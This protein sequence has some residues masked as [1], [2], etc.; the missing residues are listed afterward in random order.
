MKPGS[1]QVKEL[2]INNDTKETHRFQLS[3]S[4]FAMGRNGAPII[5]KPGTSSEEDMKYALSKWTTLTPSYI[6]LKSGE[7]G[8]V[9]ITVR[10]PNDETGNFAAWTLISVDNIKAKTPLSAGNDPKSMSIG[11][12]PNF[13]FGIYVFQ[14]PPNVAVNNVEIQKV[15]FLDSAGVKNVIMNVRNVGDGIGF[16]TSYLELTSLNTGKKMKLGTKQFT[17]LPQYFRDFSYELPKDLP[18]GK[19]SAIGVIDYGNEDDI[20]IAEINL[21]IE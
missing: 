4:D 18:K 12:N 10:I 3:F 15:R 21:T 1:T 8:K 2:L 9:R 14:N 6:E 20:K 13:G 19:Y 17:I 5:I 7:S 11:V 16:C